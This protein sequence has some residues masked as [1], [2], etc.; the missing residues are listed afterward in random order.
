MTDLDI[1][2]RGTIGGVAAGLGLAAAEALVGAARAQ[3]EPKT[4]LLIHGAWVGGWY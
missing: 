4:F 3:A 1:T 2:R